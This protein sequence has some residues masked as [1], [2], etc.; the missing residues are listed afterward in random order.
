MDE[1]SSIRELKGIGEK[2]EK[3]FAKIGVRTVGDLV[4]YFPRE[5]DVYE[6]AV[7][8]GELEENRIQTVTG[9]LYGAV[10]VGGNA[11]MQIT[12]A[13]IKDV[14]GTLHVVW[15]RMPF[16]RNTLRAGDEITLRGKVTQ[17]RGRLMMEHPEIFYPAKQYEKKLD[18]LQPIYPLTAN[19]TNNLIVKVMHQVFA[20]FFT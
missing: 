5:Y 15:Y 1:Y 12:T 8:V 2:S 14:T 10:Q 19:L 11:A 3:L 18:T 9:V 7:S 20:Q 6:R 17:K 16:L 13:C 4:Y